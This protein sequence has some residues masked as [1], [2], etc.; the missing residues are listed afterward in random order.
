[1]QHSV[2]DRK[3]ATLSFSQEVQVVVEWMDVGGAL[4]ATASLEDGWQ[5]QGSEGSRH[6]WMDM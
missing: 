1:L 3:A 6:R 5:W 4:G 2:L